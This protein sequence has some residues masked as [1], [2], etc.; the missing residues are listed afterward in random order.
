MTLCVRRTEKV[1]RLNNR[2][3]CFFIKLFSKNVLSVY[4]KKQIDVVSHQHWH[5]NHFSRTVIMAFAMRY[6]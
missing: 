1:H 3:Q 5:F 4:G 6:V 2:A